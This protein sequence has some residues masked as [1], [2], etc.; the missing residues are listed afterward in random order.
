MLPVALIISRSRQQRFIYTSQPGD[1]ARGASTEYLTTTTDGAA[2]A[3][4]VTLYIG[5]LEWLIHCADGI[6]PSSSRI[7]AAVGPGHRDR[8]R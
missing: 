3:R 8:G 4:N 7:H 6:T 1:P 5:E 2:K